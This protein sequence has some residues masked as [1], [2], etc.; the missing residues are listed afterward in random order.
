MTLG[1]LTLYTDL[2]WFIQQIL[3]DL[4]GTVPVPRTGWERM[5]AGVD[6]GR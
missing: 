2:D 4:L 1:S 3:E 5:A 6:A